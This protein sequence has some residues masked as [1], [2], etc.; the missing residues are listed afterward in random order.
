M[1][2]ITRWSV[3]AALAGLW[4]VGPVAAAKAP[5]AA[6]SRPAAAARLT[7]VSG[8]HDAA[9]LARELDRL[10]GA[11]GP[12]VRRVSIGRTRGGRDIWM[13]AVGADAARLAAPAGRAGDIR[14]DPAQYPGLLVV[15]G[16]DATQI[17]GSEE[18]L[19]FVAR[20]VGDYGRVD[21]V[22]RL[23]DR[24]TVYVAPR[25][26]PDACERFFHAPTVESAGSESPV[27]EDRDGRMDEDAPS[28]LDADGRITGM[29]VEDA[30]GEWFPDPADS[31]LMK[32]AD[33]SHGESGRF[34]LYVEGGDADHDGRIAEDGPGG[35]E[36][37]R[38]FPIGYRYFSTGAGADPMS[39]V[40]NRALA[41]FLFDHASIAAVFVFGSQDNVVQPWKADPSN[42]GA[43]ERALAAGRRGD[44]EGGDG[45]RT[46][47]LPA[48]G[49]SAPRRRGQPR[50][51]ESPVEAR[52]TAPPAAD[53]DVYDFLSQQYRRLAG[54]K[55]VPAGAPGEGDFASFVYYGM[56][57][58]AFAARPWWPA[59]PESARADS[60]A[61]GERGDEPGPRGDRGRGDVG[62]RP[63]RGGALMGRGGRGTP[64]IGGAGG[65]SAGA[66]GA[67]DAQT[68]KALAAL[69]VDAVVPWHRVEHPDF[70]GKTVEVG[71]FVPYT[72]TVPPGAL[73]DSLSAGAG[74]FL[75]DLASRLPRLELRDTNAEK[76]GPGLYRV[77]ARVV[78]PGYLPTLPVLGSTARWP[79]GVRVRVEGAPRLVSGHPIQQ[80][81]IVAGSGGSSEV[82][83]VVA[84]EAGAKLRITADCPSAG[85]AT[86]EVTLP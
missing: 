68:L 65:S 38:N 5:P 69:G 16:T 72:R 84:G 44:F 83:W 76:L 82:T 25:V 7:D 52:I 75:L 29:R 41:D 56:G 40:E 80:L 30:E 20:L 77:R 36:F 17:A 43:V 6:R 54:V 11:G 48:A 66:E 49:T 23:L 3:V 67:S 86:G 70:P 35:V 24:V 58:W 21:S 53:A 59:Q 10:A 34:K 63:D 57:R 19:R 85:A 51:E 18:A 74:A 78:N 28:D 32:R 50:V 14:E 37:N 9:A 31:R 60:S 73:L 39:E 81:G 22:T 46:G 4:A 45:G 27:D 15:G 47:G 71:G 64:R 61:R 62:T 55:D 79:R 12:P 2:R 13:V 1:T 26:S 33:R 42:A 8:Y